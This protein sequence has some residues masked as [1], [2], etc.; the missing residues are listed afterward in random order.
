MFKNIKYRTNIYSVP[1]Q[2]LVCLMTLTIINWMS[3]RKCMRLVIVR[4][5][6]SQLDVCLYCNC[7]T[8]FPHCCQNVVIIMCHRLYD[9]KYLKKLIRDNKNAKFLIKILWMMD[10]FR[11]IVI[12][13]Y[14]FNFGKLKLNSREIN[15]RIFFSNCHPFTK[16]ES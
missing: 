7:Y 3:Q 13:N 15:K 6:A 8:V 12:L 14:K 10:I 1:T 2:C 5:G 16:R 9:L 4:C 11:I